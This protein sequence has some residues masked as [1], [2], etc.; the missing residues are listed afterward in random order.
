MP[1][2]KFGTDGWR[3][4]I[5]DD[6]TFANLS[7]VTRATARWVQD[8]YGTE[9]QVVLGHDARFLGREFSEHVACVLAAEGIRV[10]L[11][12]GFTSTPAISWA[13]REYGCAAGV[14]VTA[15]H[16][17]AKYNGFK[18]KANF[19]GPASPEMI[20]EVEQKLALLSSQET[21]Q[22]PLRP[23][24]EFCD[25]EIIEERD[26]R[27]AYLDMV[28]EA[29][30]IEAI[31]EA[32][33]KVAH[34]AMFGAGQGMFS[35]L[36]GEDHVVELHSEW[37][38]G[39][40]GQAP[41]PI[42]RSTE[43]LSKVVVEQDCAAGIANDG[44]ADRIG[45]YD[46]EG[47]FVDSH[48]MLALLVKYLSQERGMEGDIVKTFST[49]HL[50]N[51]MGEAYGLEV[52]TTPIGFKHIGP[53]MVEGNVL[54]G[55]EESGGLAIKG[56]IPERDGIYIGLVILEM[57]ARRGRSLSELVQELFDE[58]G[59]HAFRRL[60]LHVPEERK[61]TILN[62]LETEAIKNLAG[63]EIKRVDTMDGF[64]HQLEDGWLLIRP[65]GT[66][67]VLRIYA[68]ADTDAAAG[69]LIDSVVEQL[70]IDGESH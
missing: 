1:E 11:G 46:E 27:G 70:G 33:F 55:G 10:L 48:R 52:H 30:D 7:A 8:N 40:Q 13:T 31:R 24:A 38:P 67:P 18:I 49:T 5:A 17:P 58:F 32:G 54:V 44:D 62:R 57:M 26:I 68:E 29:I 28:R 12:E 45:M 42:A 22:A 36:L 61:R 34:D 51:K 53:K 39:F 47:R 19:G 50:L 4:I 21:P 65:S 69:E 41:E 20:A 9:A 15:S 56:H 64:K 14:V 23:F 59:T 6:Y 2:I 63:E 35:E 43:E 16:N 25:Q 60:D 66:E 3:A 37:N